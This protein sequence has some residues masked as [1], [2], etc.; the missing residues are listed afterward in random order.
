MSMIV[1]Y[2]LLI[3]IG[4]GAYFYARSTRRRSVCASCGEVVRMEHD[5]VEH[6]PSCGALLR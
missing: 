6:C 5:T 3:A 4:V 2:L 1:V